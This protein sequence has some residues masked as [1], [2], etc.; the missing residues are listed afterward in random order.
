MGRVRA[1]GRAGR[2]RHSTV[3]KRHTSTTGRRATPQKSAATPI[4]LRASHTELISHNVLLSVLVFP[5]TSLHLL[6][7]DRSSWQHH[8]L[9]ASSLALWPQ[10]C[11]LLALVWQ[12]G[13]RTHGRVGERTNWRGLSAPL[14]MAAF[15]W[16]TPQP[17]MSHAP[18]PNSLQTLLL[19]EVPLP[20]TALVEELDQRLLLQLRDGRK[21]LGCLR[22]FDQFAN[23]VL[24][25]AVERIIVGDQYAD[26]PLG[27]QAR[28]T[29]RTGPCRARKS[30]LGRPA[31][32]HGARAWAALHAH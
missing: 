2:A 11:L 13:K 16:P 15:G 1:G 20:G 30:G 32:L 9:C 31:V 3:Q 8:A 18:Q 5:P 4:P 14:A 17:G 26:I 6:V 24:E 25:G 7:H 19:E 22:S 28:A 12:S 29:S 23:L 27:L 10:P 21:V